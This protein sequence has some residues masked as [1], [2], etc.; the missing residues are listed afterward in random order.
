MDL[1]TKRC[2]CGA[3]Y[4]PTVATSKSCSKCESTVLAAQRTAVMALRQFETPSYLDDVKSLDPC[5][6]HPE[7]DEHITYK[8]WDVGEFDKVCVTYGGHVGDLPTVS[9]AI[10]YKYT[11]D[12]IRDAMHYSIDPM[13][14]IFKKDLNR[15]QKRLAE[16][17]YTRGANGHFQ[18]QA[19]EAMREGVRKLFKPREVHLPPIGGWTEATGTQILD[20][21]N[22]LARWAK[23]AT[24]VEQAQRHSDPFYDHVDLTKE[25]LEEFILDQVNPNRLRDSDTISSIQHHAVMWLTSTGG[26]DSAKALQTS[27]HGYLRFDVTFRGRTGYF[28]LQVAPA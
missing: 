22:T 17:G 26:W 24:E 6:D 20:D 1:F 27:V 15:I 7:T 23:Q 5:G 28:W 2:G 16:S 21:L 19:A 13:F 12:D 10:A 9:E 3:I 14:D 8:D 25:A 4:K 11:T 18:A